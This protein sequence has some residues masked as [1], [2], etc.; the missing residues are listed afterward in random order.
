M[1]VL[2]QRPPALRALFR[3]SL[4]LPGRHSVYIAEPLEGTAF[5]SLSSSL[6]TGYAA[7]LG[8]LRGAEVPENWAG[9]RSAT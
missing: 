8:L 5:S 4:W 2:E 9:T 7:F 3:R 1:E 6:M